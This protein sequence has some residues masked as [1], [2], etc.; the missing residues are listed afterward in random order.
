MSVIRLLL[1]LSA[2]ISLVGALGP[3][4]G[5]DALWY[6]LTI[7][8]L[9]SDAGRIFHLPG[10]L[11]YYSELPRLGEMLFLSGLSL[12]GQVGAH[13]V[14]WAAGVGSGVGLY[15]LSRRYLD[16]TR[17]LLAT[18]LFYSTPLVGWLSGSGYVDLT[19]TLF[20]VLA[21]Y[22]ILQKRVV[23]AGV[24]LGLAISI[25]T[26]SL[27]SFVPLIAV[28]Y[29]VFKKVKPV[30]VLLFV[31]SLISLPWFI[32]AY[33]N[34]GYPFFPLGAGILDQRH[35]LF[36][37]G[38]NVFSLLTD[39]GKLALFPEDPISPLY[40]IFLPF[41][42][43]RV[44]TL[45]KRLG[46]ILVY[47][48][49]SYTLW[50]ITPRTGGGRFLLPYLPAFSLVCVAALGFVEDRVVKKLLFLSII[51]G[52]LINIAYRGVA[53]SRL[54]PFLL[55]QETREEYLCRNLDFATMVFF[56]CD[57]WFA[58]NIRPTDL[59]LVAGVHNLY[60]INFPFVHETWYRG[61]NFNYLVVQGDENQPAEKYLTSNSYRQ[62]YANDLTR[63]RV[64]RF[65]EFIP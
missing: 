34:T 14:S 11:L 46:P 4:L 9:Y 60:Y 12:L 50:W 45:Y 37:Q 65:D 17:S 25:K 6:H 2:A 42:L 57:G 63:V 5:F 55:G 3:E 51:A 64:Y 7:P 61:E 30:V 31:A 54:L 1:V 47:A 24:S 10:G 27:G 22:F 56:D 38:T 23:L 35:D 58:R 32:S 13:L 44:K 26:L 52:A 36:P 8:K 16:R 15:F 18:L 29:L 33:L 21:L 40:L 28:T 20:E 41:V 59:V 43:F 53:N 49:L 62:V 39:F 19:R 48:V